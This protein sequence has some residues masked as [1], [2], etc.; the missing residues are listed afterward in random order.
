[1]PR[2]PGARGLIHTSEKFEADIHVPVHPDEKATIVAAAD[3]SSLTLAEFARRALRDAALATERF[4]YVRLP[5]GSYHP[6]LHEM[7]YEFFENAK[8]F[9]NR[10]NGQVIRASLSPGL[11]PSADGVPQA[12][13]ASVD[14][15]NVRGEEGRGTGRG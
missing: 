4:F 3:R 8:R 10:T 7:G 2:R 15:G 13:G 1:M 9:A 6:P 12:D 14:H 5:N 11:A